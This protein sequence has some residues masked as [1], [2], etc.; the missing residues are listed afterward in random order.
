MQE[1][2][3]YMLQGKCINNISERKSEK[4]KKIE[5]HIANL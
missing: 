4:K 1:L 2:D 5:N 3:L